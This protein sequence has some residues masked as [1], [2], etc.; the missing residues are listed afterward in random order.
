MSTSQCFGL[1]VNFGDHTGVVM[2]IYNPLSI[3]L[4]VLLINSMHQCCMMQC[5]LSQV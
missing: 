5:G 4:I 2:A 3:W 1:L